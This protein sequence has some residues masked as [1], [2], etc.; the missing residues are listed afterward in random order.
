MKIELVPTT[1]N[2]E[3]VLR[4]LWQLY[5]YD[6]SEHMGLDVGDDGLFPAGSVLAR[7]WSDGRA[8]ALWCRV[9][10]QLAGF[11]ILDEQSRLT[12]APDVMD[13]AEFFVMRKYRRRG[14]GAACAALAF[15]RF[16]RR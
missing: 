13:V 1:S 7:C 9:D 11:V 5:A 4:R 16:P 8:H 6:F 14:V 3:P 12:G 10:A 2:D 15:D